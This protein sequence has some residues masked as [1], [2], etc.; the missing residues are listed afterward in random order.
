MAG[1]KPVP[2]P[3]FETFGDNVGQ[4][5][6]A[7]ITTTT[8]TMVANV[9]GATANTEIQDSSAN[10]TQAEFR[11]FAK[12]LVQQINAAKVDVAAIKS[13]LQAAGLMA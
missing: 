11:V 8:L 2:G 13:A 10:L 5:A 12:T 7:S 6:E 3:I 1:R 9:S 4:A